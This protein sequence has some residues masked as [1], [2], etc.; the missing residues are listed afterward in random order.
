MENVPAY[1]RRNVTLDETNKSNGKQNSAYMINMDDD[2]TVFVSNNS[3]LYNNV[4]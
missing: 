4:D 1:A 3:F 2:S